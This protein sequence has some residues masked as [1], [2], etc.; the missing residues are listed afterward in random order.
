MPEFFRKFQTLFSLWTLIDLM[1][2]LL[3]FVTIAWWVNLIFYY[4]NETTLYVT[5]TD[6]MED[7][8]M[9]TTNF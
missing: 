2:Y 5:N 8:D 9:V 4:N 3:G 1:F 6:Y 7:H